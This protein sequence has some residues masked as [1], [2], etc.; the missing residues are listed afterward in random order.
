[1]VSFLVGFEAELL[2]NSNEGPCSLLIPDFMTY[3]LSPSL[4]LSLSL[5]TLKCVELTL[6]IGSHVLK[7]FHPGYK[8]IFTN[9]VEISGSLILFKA[10]LV[11]TKPKFYLNKYIFCLVNKLM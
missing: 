8:K 11:N 4:S 2:A 10:L 1:L 7:T 9:K 6:P 5:Y 3:S